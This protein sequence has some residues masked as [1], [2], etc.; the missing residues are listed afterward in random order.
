MGVQTKWIP[1]SLGRWHVLLVVCMMAMTGCAGISGPVGESNDTVSTTSPENTTPHS[2]T[3]ENLKNRSDDGD[4]QETEFEFTEPD[5]T[6]H[7]ENPFGKETLTVSLNHSVDDR[8][9]APVVKDSLDYWNENSEEYA[10]Y[11]VEFHL[12]EN[13]TQP[14]IEIIF[15]PY[16]ES[17]GTNDNETMMGCA[18]VNTHVAPKTSTV[19]VE[20]NYTEHTTEE[21]VNHEIGHTLGLTHDDEPQEVMAAIIET[22]S[23]RSNPAVYVDRQVSY[24]HSVEREVDRALTYVEDGADGSIESSPSF[25]GV[26]NRS[27]ADIIIEITADDTACGSPEYS[28]CIDSDSDRS[29]YHDQTVVVLADVETETIGWNIAYNLIVS[30][31]IDHNDIPDDF[32]PDTDYNTR[33]G[34][35][36]R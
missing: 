36:W 22:G 33:S 27:R 4:K 32:A 7:P 10:G 17:C 34:S 31:V 25:N 18:P 6:V 1:P 30:Y 19:L 12:E 28:S 16:V 14:D 15:V 21:T 29:E 5:E 3:D 26:D 9:M 11:P 8:D 24:P 13:A 23:S 35:W 20:A 2:S